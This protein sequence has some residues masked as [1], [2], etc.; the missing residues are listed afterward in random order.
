MTEKKVAGLKQTSY[1]DYVWLYRFGFVFIIGH[2][3]LLI[4][5]LSYK[6]D[7]HFFRYIHFWHIWT[8]HLFKGITSNLSLSERPKEFFMALLFLTGDIGSQTTFFT[9]HSILNLACTII[10]YI[11]IFIAWLMLII[12]TKFSAYLLLIFKHSLKKRYWFICML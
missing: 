4:F 8:Y 1:K 10:D 3:V 6:N 11:I 7:N 2:T 5:S 12:N 9:Q